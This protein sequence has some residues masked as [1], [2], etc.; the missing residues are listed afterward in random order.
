MRSHG[1]LGQNVANGRRCRFLGDTVLLL[2]VM[3]RE[4][5]L[6]RNITVVKKRHGPHDLDVLE[7]LIESGKVSVV[8]YN[9]LSDP[10]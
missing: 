4:G 3:E 9:L 8:S 6:R 10:K 2:R 1:L 5:R 7:L